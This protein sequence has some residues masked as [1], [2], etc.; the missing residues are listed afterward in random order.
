MKASIL[1]TNDDGI[2]SAFM[3]ELVN[4]LSQSFEVTVVA[5]DTHRSWVGRSI[6]RYGK[7]SIK[8]HTQFPC[9]TY[10]CSGTPVDAVNIALGHLFKVNQFPTAVCSGINIGYNV[11]MP[12]LVASGTLCAAME[13]LSWNVRGI[14]FSK[15]LKDDQLNSALAKNGILEDQ[16][17]IHSLKHSANRALQ[18]TETLLQEPFRP[19][20][21]HNINFP[22]DLDSST[23]IKR[24]DG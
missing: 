22:I 2:E 20:I 5:P 8:E 3:W 16:V 7:V 6:T 21:L 13:A 9:R 4:A 14:A 24:I 12:I 19:M 10:S 11:T 1:V 17:A 18:I 23:L 15:H